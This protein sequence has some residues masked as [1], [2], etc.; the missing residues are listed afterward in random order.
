M[1]RSLESV[2]IHNAPPGSTETDIHP[3]PRR[4]SDFRVFMV[5]SLTPTDTTLSAMLII[6]PDSRQSSAL[7]KSNGQ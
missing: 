7:G 2:A 5:T 4:R 6:W 3:R 1:S